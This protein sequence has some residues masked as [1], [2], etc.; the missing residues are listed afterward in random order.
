ML[1]WRSGSRIKV[2]REEEE[3][4]ACLEAEGPEEGNLP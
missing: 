4:F 3:S 1:H 2:E